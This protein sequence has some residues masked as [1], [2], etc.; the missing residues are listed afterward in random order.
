MK[1]ILTILTFFVLT[2]SVKSANYYFAN[3]GSDGNLGTIGSPWQTITKFNSVFSSKSPGDSF[4]FK[5]G[6]TFNDATMSISRS[7]NSTNSI[8]IAAYGSGTALP[9]ISGGVT[10]SSWSS[11]GGGVYKSSLATRP[12]VVVIGGHSYAEGRYPNSGWLT[13]DS[14]SSNHLTSSGL[15]GQTGLV[16]ADVAIRSNRSAMDRYTISSQVGNT[17]GFPGDIDVGYG[18]FIENKLST[19]DQYGEWFYNSSTSELNVYFGGA[20]TSNAT[21]SS[22]NRVLEISGFNYL[23]FYNLSFQYGQYAQGNTMI[24]IENTDHVKFDNSEFKFSGY[25]AIIAGDQGST[26]LTI[27][28][29]TFRDINNSAIKIY[30][31]VTNDGLVIENNTVTTIG[32]LLGGL[33]NGEG[34]GIG[35]MNQNSANA[36]IR[37][38][39]ID[40]ISYHGLVVSGLNLQCYGNYITHWNYYLDDGGGI[41]TQDPTGKANKRVFRNIVQYGGEHSSEGTDA[42]GSNQAYG[43]YSDGGNVNEEIDSNVT[44]NCQ[45]G[46]YMDDGQN[47]NIHNNI[48]YNCTVPIAIDYVGGTAITG[49]KV[50]KNQM[51][52]TDATYNVY[53]PQNQGAGSSISTWGTAANNDSNYIMRP[54]AQTDVIY[55]WAGTGSGQHLTISQWALLYGFDAHSNGSPAWS[56]GSNNSLVYNSTQSPVTVTTSRKFK[57]TYGNTYDGAYTLQP[58]QGKILFDVGASTIDH[59]GTILIIH[60]RVII[61]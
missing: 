22:R 2:L 36:I 50:K 12:A 58:Y 59:G 10:V 41:Y 48:A 7:G 5:R 49:L 44:A 40:S 54:L 61:N 14:R 56:T 3:S 46:I 23:T 4:L 31:S 8:I 24:Y 15:T 39:R 11:V 6:D 20:G 27:S 53:A 30:G 16:G 19:L 38:N 21:V 18:F 13:A 60:R 9:I 37:Y 52:A 33:E 43:I 47:I 35:L 34:I 45:S 28:N 1:L 51:L 57:D 17:I 26:N 29:N 25:A 42:P 32:M 55:T